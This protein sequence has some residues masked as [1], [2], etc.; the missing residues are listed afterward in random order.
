MN[1]PQEV[2]DKKYITSKESFLGDLQIGDFAFIKLEKETQPASVKRLWK[3]REF[4]LVNGNHEAIFD[5]ICQFD[6]IR[7]LQFEALDLFGLDMNLL[8]PTQISLG[9][10]CQR[11]TQPEA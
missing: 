4:Q 6:P 11:L 1:V 5:E 7:L 3:L 8:I 10:F 9:R 2:E